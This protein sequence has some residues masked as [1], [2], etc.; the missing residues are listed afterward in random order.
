MTPPIR[1]LIADDHLI[2][3]KGLRLMLEEMG[4]SIHL[5]GEA[6]DG[7]AAVR[8]VGE[9]QPE[10]V[11]MDLRMPGMDGLEALEQ[12][13]RAFPQVAV[14]ILTIYNED[15]LMIRGLRAGACGY[16]LKDTSQETLY[17]AI[18]TAARGA[19]V[20]QPDTM[21]RLLSQIPPRPPALTQ[22]AERALLD[23]TEREREVLEAVACGER[24]KEIAARLGITT[25]TVGAHL[26]SIY[27]KLGVDSRTAAVALALEHGVLKRSQS[28][29]ED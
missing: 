13:R 4:D 5:V 28:Q 25:R 11:L 27:L 9:V 7:A 14:V 8:L 6:E 21:A 17:Q 16:L 29:P 12:I 20:L 26:T 18:C 1:V 22:T 23:L 10:V 24:S 2:V 3:R 15:A 19:L